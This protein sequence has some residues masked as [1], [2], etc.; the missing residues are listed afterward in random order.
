M[1]KLLDENSSTSS[2]KGPKVKMVKQT[3]SELQLEPG[4][5]IDLK[6]EDLSVKERQDPFL[7]ECRAE[8]RERFL[9]AMT[10]LTGQPMVATMME[11][12]TVTGTLRGID[13]DG[14]MVHV[15]NLTTPTA[16]FPW[17]T[18]RLPD[19]LAINFEM[20]GQ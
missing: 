8:L 12:L 5:D 17:A 7:Q 1:D 14:L 11:H 4:I 13:K 6:L 10:G 19:C 3:K 15:E 2:Q 16:V 20:K 9:W 18:L